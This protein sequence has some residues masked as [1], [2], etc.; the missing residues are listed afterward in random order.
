MP[1]KIEDFDKCKLEFEFC[2]EEIKEMAR[3]IVKD[4]SDK[5]FSIHDAKTVLHS[6]E[7]LMEFNCFL[8]PCS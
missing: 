4:F 6:C 3:R 2:P 1:E 5:K 7:I 8:N